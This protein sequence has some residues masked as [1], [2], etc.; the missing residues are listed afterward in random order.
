MWYQ[1]RFAALDSQLVVLLL[2]SAASSLMQR[3]QRVSLQNFQPLFYL[4]VHGSFFFFLSFLAIFN[5]SENTESKK[6]ARLVFVN[7]PKG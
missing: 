3:L 5:Q 7:S 2:L 6:K 4:L 1:Y